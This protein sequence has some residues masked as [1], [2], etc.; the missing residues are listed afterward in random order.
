MPRRTFARG[1]ELTVSLPSTRPLSVFTVG[2]EVDLCGRSDF[3]AS[4]ARELFGTA[5][6][7][8]TLLDDVKRFQEEFSYHSQYGFHDNGVNC[9]HDDGIHTPL[10]PND[11]LGLVTRIYPAP[12]YGAGAHTKV[13]SD[14]RDYTL[15]YT[16]TVT[17]PPVLDPG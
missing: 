17:P 6:D 9:P 4:A 15:R 3:W 12:G 14:Q 16:I 1:T 13:V 2:S 5:S 7:G 10:D 11:R 8:P